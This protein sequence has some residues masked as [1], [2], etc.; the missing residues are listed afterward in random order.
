MSTTPWI[1]SRAD[2]RGTEQRALFV[3]SGTF[4]KPGPDQFHIYFSRFSRPWIP[5][6]S[7][8]KHDVVE[9]KSLVDFVQSWCLWVKLSIMFESL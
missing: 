9:T 2:R 8:V 6:V 4:R 7:S 1:T 3:I 5:L